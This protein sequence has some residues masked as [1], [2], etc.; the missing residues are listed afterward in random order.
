VSA[1]I[2]VDDEVAPR[3]DSLDLA[4]AAWALLFAALWGG[5]ATS[6]KL[7]LQFVPRLGLAG[8]RFGLGFLALALWA[9]ATRQPLWLSA[10]EWR[11][12]LPLSVL[13]VLQIVSFSF[14]VDYGTASHTVVLINVHPLFVALLAHWLLHDDR[15][16]P[17]KLVGL[18]AAFAGVVSLFAEQWIATAPG[19]LLGDAL[20]LLSAL[21][22]S[23]VLV[24]TKLLTRTMTPLKLLVGQYV[25]GVPAY[26]ALGALFDPPGHWRLEAGALAPL[27]YQ[28]VIVSG[29]CFIGWTQLLQRYPA[30]KLTAISFVTPLCGAVIAHWVLNEPLTIGLALGGML[31]ALGVLMANQPE[32]GKNHSG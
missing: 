18:V 17:R 1:T 25:V 26:F 12:V 20:G 21:L 7:S 14:G 4:G 22:L 24:K 27:L 19:L 16:H 6:A 28:G 10:R 11:A 5:L 3:A 2:R 13:F 32:N 9:L 30:S 31:V 29:L 15:L 8:V 23:L